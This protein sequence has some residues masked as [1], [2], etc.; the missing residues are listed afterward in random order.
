MDADEK[1]VDEHAKE[2]DSNVNACLH[3]EA[4]KCSSGKGRGGPN[5]LRRDEPLIAVL[6]LLQ[7]L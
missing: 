5:F 3:A 1:T 7:R 2:R 4:A 6:L